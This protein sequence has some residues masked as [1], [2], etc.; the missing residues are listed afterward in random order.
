MSLSRCLASCYNSTWVTAV[1]RVIKEP[2]G[3]GGIMDI[4]LEPADWHTHSVTC[5][6]LCSSYSM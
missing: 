1:T 5:I 4:V 6:D 3:P 2:Q